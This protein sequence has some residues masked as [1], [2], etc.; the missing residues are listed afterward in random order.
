MLI[1]LA[2]G[3]SIQ[4]PL[5]VHVCISNN[6]FPSYVIIAPEGLSVPSLSLV[7]ATTLLIEWSPPPRPNGMILSYRSN[8]FDGTTTTTHNQ[9]LSTSTLI[10]SLSPFT[11]YQITITVFNTEGSVDSPTANITTGE[12]GKI[13][14][15]LFVQL[16]LMRACS[17]LRLIKLGPYNN[18]CNKLAIY[19]YVCI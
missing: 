11:L 5:Q 9:G 7:N 10:Y 15:Q 16:S 4:E 6:F 3:N 12:T 2:I 18:F 8:L 1:W 19:M 13:S 14:E 17:I